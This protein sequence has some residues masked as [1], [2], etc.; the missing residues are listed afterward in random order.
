MRSWRTPPTRTVFEVECQGAGVGAIGGGGRYDGLMELEGGKPTPGIGFAVGFE[1][2]Y[3]ALQTL[4]VN[5]DGD[6]PACVYVACTG[7]DEV[8]A[9]VATLRDMSTHEQV[10]VP[11]A[12]LAS[13]VKSRLA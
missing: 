7:S 4:G 8:A 13:E 3:L 11:M 12:D 1:R 2:M 6:E 10:Q 5:V 9:G